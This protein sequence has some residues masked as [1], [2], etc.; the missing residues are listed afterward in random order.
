M[1]STPQIVQA[2]LQYFIVPLWI[3]AGTADW[4]CHRY[5]GIERNAGTR[6]SI[7]HLIMLAQVGVPVC[8]ALFLEINALVIA[9][10]IVA[11]VAH[12]LTALFDLRYTVNRRF[13]GPFEQQ[14]HSFLELMPMVAGLL[15][16]IL[17]WPQFLSLFGRGDEAPDFALRAKQHPLSAAYVTGV[18][19]A[20]VLLDLAPYL[21]EFWRCRRSESNLNP[22]REGHRT[23]YPRT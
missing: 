16:V 13:I 23:W 15:L 3:I 17:H 22:T 5:T 21:E 4:A 14:V 20:V 12:Q 7:F 2:V 1:S 18:L 9:L 6:E 8:A 10:I 11:L 19:S